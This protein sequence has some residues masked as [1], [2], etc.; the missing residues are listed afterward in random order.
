VEGDWKLVA[1]SAIPSPWRAEFVQDGSD[2]KVTVEQVRK[3]PGEFGKG[4]IAS[5][6]EVEEN[7]G[8]GIGTLKKQPRD[9][10]TR[11][12]VEIRENEFNVPAEEEQWW[13]EYGEEELTEK[14]ALETAKVGGKSIGLMFKSVEKGSMIQ[15]RGVKSGDI[16]KSING[17]PV[18]TR[19]EVVNYLNKEGKG[20]KQYTVVMERDGKEIK[21]VYNVKPKK[22]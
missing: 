1:V 20:L 18:R 3:D 2:E 11:E 21:K 12:L 9:R 8:P 17:K 14:V 4:P 15:R 16:L 10:P 22:K 13:G 19:Q 6:K 5:V 7:N